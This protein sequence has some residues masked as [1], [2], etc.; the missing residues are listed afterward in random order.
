MLSKLASGKPPL[1]FIERAARRRRKA[2]A[3][4]IMAAIVLALAAVIFT[5]LMRLRPR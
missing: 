1:N 3:N 5:Q 2:K 4:F